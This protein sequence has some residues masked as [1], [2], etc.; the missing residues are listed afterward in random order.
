MVRGYYNLA[1]DPLAKKITLRVTYCKSE[2]QAKTKL[3]ITKQMK[4]KQS[5]QQLEDANKY[6]KQV[7]FLLKRFLR[8]SAERRIFSMVA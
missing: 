1:F 3:K 4:Q 5:K 6:I 8:Q 7:T 2:D